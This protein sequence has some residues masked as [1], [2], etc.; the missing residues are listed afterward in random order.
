M[1]APDCRYLAQ[2]ENTISLH[3]FH[4]SL[5]SRFHFNGL[6]YCHIQ[7]IAHYLHHHRRLVIFV[8]VLAPLYIIIITAYYI[9]A[10][11]QGIYIY[12]L[13]LWPLRCYT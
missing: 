6:P 12:T 4:C 10:E 8:M 9:R 13:H 1:E 2:S 11:S 5:G 7:S 3:H